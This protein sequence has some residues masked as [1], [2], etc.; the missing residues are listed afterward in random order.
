KI[1]I[2]VE[3]EGEG[4]NSKVK[5]TTAKSD[6]VRTKKPKPAKATKFEGGIDLGLNNFINQESGSDI[7]DLKPLG[8]RYVSLNWHV[9]S[10]VGG[11]KSPL[12]IISGLEFAFNNYM[13]DRN[14]VIEEDQDQTFFR[15]A[16]EINYEKSK[17]TH[18][19]VN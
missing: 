1:K 15:R 3:V 16:T 14:F 10:R 19:S 13:F 11:T 7:P 5:V 2:D 4:D 12:Y 9:Q 8:S 17:L 6:T 18:S